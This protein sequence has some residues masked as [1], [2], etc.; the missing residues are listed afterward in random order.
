MRVIGWFLFNPAFEALQRPVL[1][2][3]EDSH[4]TVSINFTGLLTAI[5]MRFRVSFFL[6]ILIAS[7]WWLY[8]LWAFV[9][10]GLERREKAYTV[11]FLGAAIPL[12]AGG[13]AL[14][15]A[16]LPRAVSVLA[17]F[18]PEGSTNL[19]D[20]QMY[21]TFVMHVLVGLG[22]AAVLP[23]VMVAMTWI[24]IVAPRTWLRGWRWAVIIILV[25]AAFITPTPDILS[26][27]FLAGPMLG[28]YF[29]A[30][31]IGALRWRR[32]REGTA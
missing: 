29:L 9:A 18:V 11:G 10:P 27:L 30:I 28:L 21:L 15:W 12:F 19:I 31:G 13:V 22:L 14:G 6:G 32:R 3:A 16:V 2:A 26:M 5:D 1:Q 7:P 24:G 4:A 20:A 17:G 25:A 23:V 8:Q